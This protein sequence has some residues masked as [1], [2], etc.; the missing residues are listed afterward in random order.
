LFVMVLT[1]YSFQNP[2]KL[3]NSTLFSVGQSRQCNLWLND[4]SISTV[5]C[6]LKHIEVVLF[7]Q[8][9]VCNVFTS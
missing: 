8:S 6:K 3:M 2:H 5:L 4:P 9:N 1:V 7:A